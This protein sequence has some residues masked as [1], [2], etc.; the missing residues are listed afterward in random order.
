MNRQTPR[1]YDPVAPTGKKPVTIK[2]LFQYLTSPKPRRSRKI[3][4]AIFNLAADLN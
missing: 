1:G 4:I 2:I 3:K